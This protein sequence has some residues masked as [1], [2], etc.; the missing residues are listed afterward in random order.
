MKVFKVWLLISMSLVVVQCKEQGNRELLFK[1]E[2][3][4]K[5]IEV[6][7]EGMSFD[8]LVFVVEGGGR[9]AYLLNKFGKKEFVWEF[10][11]PL[12]NELE[13][14]PDGNVIGMFKA[15]DASAKIAG[16]YGGIIRIISP[17]GRIV[18]EYEYNSYD[19]LA[20]HDL[21]VL[22]NGHVLFLA[23]ERKVPKE[24]SEY[25]MVT[26][27]DIFPEMLVEV[28]PATNEVVWE[29]H[30]WDHL[31]QD[32]DQKLANYGKVEDAPRRIDINYSR[33]KHG[34]IMHANG[35]EVDQRKDLVY[36][37]V[38]NYDEIWVID[39]S[40]TTDEAA[41]SS[42]GRYGKGGDILYRFGNPAAYKNPKGKKIFDKL[43]FPNLIREGY[44]GAGNMLVFANGESK[45]QS[46]V[47]ELELP[48]E[49][50]L[51]PDHDNEPKIVWSFS[52][53]TL[54]YG[55]ISGADRI[56]NGNTLICEGDLGFWEVTSEKQVVWKYHWASTSYWRGY[57]FSAED[58]AIRNVRNESGLDTE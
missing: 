15:E 4:T 24:A 7:D 44:P 51:Q 6:K 9:T 14:L 19:Y 37:S 39:H 17:D 31:V 36:I 1:P 18:W 53:S 46:V 23:W 10:D 35:L 28:N 47:Y 21:E 5:E 2:L 13:L 45:R 16:G 49:F 41:K 58:E 34:D 32:V 40:T 12:G 29:W 43:H 3:W 38:N 8:D 27:V 54:F 11:I 56:K 26:D 25:G 55:R 30:S 52:D 57:V 48:K 50:S 42:G 20:H 33:P 22:D